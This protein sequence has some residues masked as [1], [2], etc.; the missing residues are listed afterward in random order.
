LARLKNITATFY[1]LFTDS[2]NTLF[3]TVAEKLSINQ[4]EKKAA[5]LITVENKATLSPK[6]A[7]LLLIIKSNY[8]NNFYAKIILTPQN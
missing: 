4:C 5:H 8:K 6:K 3:L 7:Y 1:K 2:P